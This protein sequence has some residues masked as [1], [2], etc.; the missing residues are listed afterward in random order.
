[1]FEVTQTTVFNFLG[2]KMVLKLIKVPLNEERNEILLE[3]IY[4]LKDN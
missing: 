3:I 4:L 1:M 2:T